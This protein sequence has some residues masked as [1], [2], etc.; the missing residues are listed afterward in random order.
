MCS[1]CR[2]MSRGTSKSPGLF[3]VKRGDTEKLELMVEK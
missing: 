1:S 3:P 2:S